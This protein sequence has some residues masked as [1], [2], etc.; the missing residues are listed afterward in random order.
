MIPLLVALLLQADLAR[1]SSPTLT[2]YQR[3]PIRV[4]AVTLVPDGDGWRVIAGTSEGAVS[5]LVGCNDHNAT[6]RLMVEGAPRLT[7]MLDC[8]ENKGP[9]K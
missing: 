5:G 6:R 2:F 4:H 8:P 1:P 7:I 3:K 9:E